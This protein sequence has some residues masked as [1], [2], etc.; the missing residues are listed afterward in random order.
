MIVIAVLS[1]ALVIFRAIGFLGVTALDSWLKVLPFALAVML[2][3]TA[4]AHFISPRKEDLAR[5][6]PAWL[7]RPDAIIFMTGVLE[8]LGAVGLL[9]P[10]TRPFAARGLILLFLAMFPANIRAAQL[11]LTLAGRAATP[12]WLRVP[13]QFL[14]ITLTFLASRIR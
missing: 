12:L 10:A 4:S 3:F 5:M 14:F 9:I 1:T 8:I 2:F 13:M 7:P 11:E 6:V